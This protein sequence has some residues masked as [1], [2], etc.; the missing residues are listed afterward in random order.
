MAHVQTDM[1]TSY[2]S[3]CVDDVMI[4]KTIKSFPNQKVL[5]NG[6]VRALSRAKKV[7]FWSGDKNAYCTARARLKAGIKEAK[8]RHQERLERDLNTNNTKDVA[9]NPDH[10]RLQKQEYSHHVPNELN[11]FYAGFDVLN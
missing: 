3:K 4:T 5:M 11:T 7:A 2:I 10:H 9:G 1:M 6:E 8:Q